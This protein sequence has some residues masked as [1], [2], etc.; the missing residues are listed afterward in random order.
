MTYCEFHLFFNVPLIVFLFVLARPR[1]TPTH[2]KWIGVV[3]LIV[4]LFATPWDS[5]AV[6][7][8]IWEFNRSQTSFRIG[9]LPVEEILF[10]VLATLEASLLTVLFLPKA[11]A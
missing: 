1:L 9:V 2:W 5:W 4:L 6:H 7:K 10:F 11:R 8:K 3:M